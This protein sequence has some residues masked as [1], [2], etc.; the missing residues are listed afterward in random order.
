MRLTRREGLASGIVHEQEHG[1]RWRVGELARATG[2]TVRALH[3][4]D[5]VGLLRSRQR[6][7]T[8]HRL[9][10]SEDVHRLYRIIALRQLGMSLDQIARSLDGDP[11][12]LA[13]AVSR[14]LDHVDA[15]LRHQQRIRQ[16]LIALREA[17]RRGEAPPDQLLDTIEVIMHTQYFSDDQLQQ[18]KRRHDSVGAAGFA[19]W[20]D[21][22][23]TLA[24]EAS[25]LAERGTDP[26]DQSAQDLARRWAAVMTDLSGG[27]RGVLSAIYAKLDGEG[28]YTASKGI[29]PQSA[30]DY[31][32]HA[33]AV[34]FAP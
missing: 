32:K 10:T 18:I 26:A 28:A 12:E 20:T 2:L 22:I 8:G 21:Q 14:Q 31:L 9:Y 11:Q 4:F 34:G 25:G 17:M 24:G 15:Q 29:L 30:W 7:A 33:L 1:R 6:S 13:T 3:H 27:D 19:R 23:T 5:E 16:H